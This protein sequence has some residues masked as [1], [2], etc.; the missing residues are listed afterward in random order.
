M[1]NPQ[2]SIIIPIYNAEKTLVICIQKIIEQT[3]S[4]W[5]L[6][7]INDGS[8]DRSLEIC[9]KAQQIDVR[10]KTINQPNGGASSARNAGL[11]AAMG[12]W[13]TFCDSDDYVGPY[14]LQNFVDMIQ[15]NPDNQTLFIQK[16][17]IYKQGIFDSIYY[18]QAQGIMDKSTFLSGH[19]GFVWNKIFKREIIS[20][21]HITFDTQVKLFEDELFV[22]SYLFHI[23]RI[24]VCHQAPQ[25]FYEWPIY[26]D[27]YQKFINNISVQ[28]RI[29]QLS[30]AILSTQPN[31]Y[32]VLIY[33]FL[34]RLMSK[35]ILTLS[36]QNTID[37]E[38][39]NSIIQ[40]TH[41]DIGHILRRKLFAL[42]I[43]SGTRRTDIWKALL[44]GHA[45]LIRWHL[46]KL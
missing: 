30:K 13:I 46:L 33:K 25:Y 12:E 11:K 19:F 39:L 27:K 26:T 5:E 14:W 6:L 35:T 15:Q 22:L 8:K 41:D 20:N 45:Y 2:I 43:L 18:E 9:L 24:V 21:Q 44:Y 3:Y 7:L 23:K 4:N 28:L 16:I 10:I 31:G 37:D 32:H 34:N 40:I 1:N 36:V 42:R 17:N 29:Y 38:T